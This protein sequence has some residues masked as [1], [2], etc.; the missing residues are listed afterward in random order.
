MHVE[1]HDAELFAVLAMVLLQVVSDELLHEVVLFLRLRGVAFAS[2][3]H[4]KT[5]DINYMYRI[6]RLCTCTYMIER[7]YSTVV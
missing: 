3:V 6:V 7:T 5:P 4:L 2:D 1:E